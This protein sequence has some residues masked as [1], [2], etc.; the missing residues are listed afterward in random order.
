MYMPPVSNTPPQQKKPT[1]EG[2]GPIIGVIIVVILLAF[3]ALYF[4]GQKLN[5][6]SSRGA[7]LVESQI[8]LD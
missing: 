3:G 8:T 6:Q 5:R 1:D 4:W 2:S 7:P